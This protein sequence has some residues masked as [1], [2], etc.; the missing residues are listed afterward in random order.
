MLCKPASHCP[1]HSTKTVKK[2]L[3]QEGNTPEVIK[4]K[5][6]P[7]D[8]RYSTMLFTSPLAER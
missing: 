4:M 1:R 7:F 8:V 6:T 5:C 3:D 2:G